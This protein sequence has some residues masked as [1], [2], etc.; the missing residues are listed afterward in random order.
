MDTTQLKMVSDSLTSQI[1]QLQGQLDGVNQAIKV[2]TDG[3]QSDQTAIDQAVVTQVSG[4]LNPIQN[5]ITST[6]TSLANAQTTTTD[7]NNNSGVAVPVV[8]N[9]IPQTPATPDDST[10]PVSTSSDQPAPTLPVS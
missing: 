9:I 1:S 4:F 10:A 7:V 8:N 3:Y 6:L 2:L 5:S